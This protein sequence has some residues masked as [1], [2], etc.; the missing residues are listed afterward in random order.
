M[1]AA[2]LPRGRV[3]LDAQLVN[4]GKDGA[5]ADAFW[6]DQFRA[7]GAPQEATLVATLAHPLGDGAS[8]L[9]SGFSLFGALV[10]HSGLE[11]SLEGAAGCV[12][13]GAVA[14]AGDADE[15][16]AVEGTVVVWV[17]RAQV[18]L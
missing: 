12:A 7:F 18:V 16:F 9:H 3:T 6:A 14:F 1:D 11:G 8:E 15:V 4:A 10:F 17:W 2:R 5:D 13:D